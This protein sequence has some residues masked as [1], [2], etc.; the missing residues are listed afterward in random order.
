MSQYRGPIASRVP[1]RIRLR[2]RRLRQDSLRASLVD[3][4]FALDGVLAVE[5]NGTTGSLLVR[6]DIARCA[7]PD[8]EAQLAERVAA[9]LGE[10]CEATSPSA[11]ASART[12]AALRRS[13]LTRR[14]VA[15]A[16]NRMSKLGMLGVYPLV[17]ALAFSGN[18]K[19]H[20]AAGGVFTLFALMHSIFHRRQ[21]LR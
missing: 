10:S 21:L 1:G 19:L 15:R 12:P 9:V 2:D 14:N 7:P 20:A 17:I 13:R 8:F 4:L 3:A 5:P 11:D 16:S 6:Y 18:K